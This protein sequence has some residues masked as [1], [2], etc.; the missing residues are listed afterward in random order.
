MHGKRSATIGLVVPTIDHA[1]FAE[2]IQVFS[3]EV[4]RAGFTILIASH[5][6]DLEKEYAV[7]RKLL[8]HRV[9]GVALI[10]L[11]HHEEVFQLIDQQQ[12]PAL[13]VWN[14]ARDSRISCVGAENLAAGAMAARHLLELR[15]RE[16]ATIFPPDHANDR[17]RDRLNGAISCLKSAGIDLSAGRQLQSLYSVRHAKSTSLELLA[18][19][20][21]P[22]AILCGNDVIAQGVVYAAATLGIGVPDELSIIGIGDFKG[23]EE[24]E[25]ALTTIHIPARTLA[26]RRLAS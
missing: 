2:L 17:A 11:N 4:E 10:G 7:L 23:S 16:I 5:N 1:I 19:P 14:W 20:E 26:G 13:A 15:H 6:Y 25:P 24:M 18:G 22:T 8:E 9:D 21:R 12:V 3:T